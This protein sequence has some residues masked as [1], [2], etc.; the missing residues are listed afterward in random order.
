MNPDTVPRPTDPSWQQ[1]SIRFD[2][3]T[4]AEHTGVAHLGP[5]TTKAESAGLVTSWSFIR[6]APCW[7]LRHLPPHHHAEQDAQAFIHQ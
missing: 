5:V 7:R 1:V 3:C 2:D 6:K 4:A